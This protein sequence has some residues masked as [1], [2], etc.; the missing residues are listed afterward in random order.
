MVLGSSIKSCFGRLD[1]NGAALVTITRMKQSTPLD[2][3]LEL[4]LATEL[5]ISHPIAVEL[6]AET[7]KFT[8]SA[9]FLETLPKEI[10]RDMWASIATNDRGYCGTVRLV[11]VGGYLSAK[12]PFILLPPDLHPC[13]VFWIVKGTAASTS[14]ETAATTTTAMFVAL[15]IT[16]ATSTR[17]IQRQRWG[18]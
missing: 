16:K 18:M 7:C 14:T 2:E 13:N 9:L 11:D 10:C 6:G 5:A 15:S 1:I 3:I 17:M 8:T 4:L 12:V